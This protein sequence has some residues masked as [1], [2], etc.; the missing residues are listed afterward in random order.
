VD[1]GAEL[2]VGDLMVDEWDEGGVDQVHA[3]P[4]DAIADAA[5]EAARASVGI[6]IASAGIAGL[7]APKALAQACDGTEARVGWLGAVVAA[8]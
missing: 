7:L 5:A 4:P 2:A 6:D 3:G 1:D 8:Q